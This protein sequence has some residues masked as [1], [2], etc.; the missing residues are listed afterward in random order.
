MSEPISE[1]GEF[2]LIERI[3]KILGAY[4]R[5]KQLLTD[6]GDDCAVWKI[7]DTRAFCATV[8]MLVE[9]VHF[10]CNRSS[11]YQIGK[12]AMSVNLSDLAAMGAK[13]LF[14]LVSLGLPPTVATAWFDDCITGMRDRLHEFHGA[15]IGGNLSS[16]PDKIV[17]DVTLV[18]ETTI[19]K[20]LTRSGAKVGD[21]IFVT[22]DIGSSAAG[23]QLLENSRTDTLVCPP[24][25][26]KHLDPTPRIHFGYMLA[27]TGIAS[28]CIDI[29]D[30]LAADLHHLCERSNCGARIDCTQIPVSPDLPEALRIINENRQE[31]IIEWNDVVLYGGEDY[32]LLFTVKPEASL[33]DLA[34]IAR[35]AKTPVN[36]IGII[37]PWEDRVTMYDTSGNH[38]PLRAHGWNHYW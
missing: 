28:A 38:L 8:D 7:D 24:I 35:A 6:L 2:G 13:P 12:R 4:P 33:L 17:I 3:E 31:R 23:L 21:R 26:Q 1:H 11:A 34:H 15:I 18:G 16:T 25:L 29:S 36:E 30:G 9:D 20:T 10:R 27:E 32:E 14:A 22:G 5:P 37:L 19:A